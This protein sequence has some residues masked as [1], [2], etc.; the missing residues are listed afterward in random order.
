[1]WWV[2]YCPDAGGEAGV[3]YPKPALSFE[4]QA[5]QLL[6]RGFEADRARLIE[7]LSRVSYYRLTAYWHPFKRA[8]DTFAPGTSLE[9]IWRRYTFDRQLRLLVMDAVER[10]EIAVLRTLMV[11]QH[12]RKYGPFGYRDEKSFRPEFAGNDHRRMLEDIDHETKR[13]REPF[14]GHFLAKY[15]S[16]PGLPLWMAAEIASYGTLFTFYR[17]LNLP[18]QKQLASQLGL[19]ASVLQSWLFNL[20]YIRNLCA[21]HSRLWN[22]E[23]AIRPFVPDAKNSPEWHQPAT[24]DNRR[25]FAVLTLLRWLLQK[26]APSSHWPDRVRALLKAYPDVPLNLMGFP[27]GWETS[28]VWTEKIK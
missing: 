17:F 23:L 21:H 24:P 2:F 9:K 22:R 20:N 25:M 3:N 7:T 4:Q 1:M 8:D 14:V 10:V 16:E 6:G 28:P 13:S 5:D 15:T 12:A 19:P 11:E 18:E 27:A 26:I